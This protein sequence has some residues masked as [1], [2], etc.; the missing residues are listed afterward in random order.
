[1]TAVFGAYPVS[2]RGDEYYLGNY[3]LFAVHEPSTPVSGGSPGRSPVRVT[4]RKFCDTG[5]VVGITCKARVKSVKRV[6]KTAMSNHDDAT[7][8]LNDLE[9]GS[10][11]T[12]IWEHLSERREA[13]ADD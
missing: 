7:N 11:C 1:M 13:Q 8:H 9:D 5:A 10:G 2:G 3:G 6:P 12:E 4:G